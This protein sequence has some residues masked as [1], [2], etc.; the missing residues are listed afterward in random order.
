M[1]VASVLSLSTDPLCFSIRL[2]FFTLGESRLPVPRFVPLADNIILNVTDVMINNLL[3][4]LGGVA[5]SALHV[6]VSEI[7]NK[8]NHHN[9]LT[10]RVTEDRWRLSQQ[11]RLANGGWEFPDTY[12]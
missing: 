2:F 3:L 12:I 4:Q 9:W 1:A 10:D 11:K 7:R 6:K 5:I 8:N